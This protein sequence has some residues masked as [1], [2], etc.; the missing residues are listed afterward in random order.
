MSRKWKYL[1]IAVALTALEFLVALRYGVA[2]WQAYSDLLPVRLLL[3]SFVAVWITSLTDLWSRVIRV[4]K[5][6]PPPRR[7]RL[8]SFPASTAV[9]AEASDV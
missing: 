6:A 8:T 7:I 4:A 1:P 2:V 3:P 9:S 5:E